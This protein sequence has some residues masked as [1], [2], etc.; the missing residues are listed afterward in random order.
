MNPKDLK[1][2]LSLKE[3]ERRWSMVRKKMAQDGLDA[4]I[5][6]GND[7]HLRDRACSY[8]T[9]TLTY[10]G[11]EHMVLIQADGEPVFLNS[12]PLGTYHVKRDSWVP[13]ENIYE[14]KKLGADLAKH[15]IRLKIQKKRI[16]IDNLEQ[17]P[18]RDYLALTESCPDIEIVDV[19]RWLWEMRTQ[20]SPEELK[21]IEEAI[22]ISELAQRT[23][24]TNLKPGMKEEVVVSK[25]EEVIRANGVER[26]LWLMNS[27]RDLSYPGLPGDTI[28]QKPN[29][30]SFSAEFQ[31]TR[32]YASQSIRTYCWEE[33]KGDYKRMFELCGEFRRMIPEEFRPGRRMSEVAAKFDSIIEEQGFEYHNMGHGLGLNFVEEPFISPQPLNP[34]WVLMP[35]EVYEF[36][37][38]IRTKDGKGPLAWIGDIYLIDEDSTRWMTP[39]LPGLP[40]II[41]G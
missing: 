2:E 19:S 27:T 15:I 16:G 18:A 37:P 38:M 3:K 36:H 32:A 9:N 12:S 1:L 40:E 11:C 31:R 17:W 33:P 22:R 14:S 20:K 23:F 34:D 10:S 39:F 8:F 5:I 4:V 41:L 24:L 26:R 30:V 35:N 25:V 13:A 6:F 29:P 28:I 21:L 7:Q